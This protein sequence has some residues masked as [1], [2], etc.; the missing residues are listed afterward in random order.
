MAVDHWDTGNPHTRVVLGVRERET[1]PRDL[2]IPAYMAHGMR[3]GAGELSTEWLDP[4]TESE[5]RR[6]LLR[7]TDQERLTSLDRAPL[8]Q[9]I[10]GGVDFTEMPGDALNK[11]PR[12]EML[13]LEAM[14]WSPTRLHP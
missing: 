11:R 7:E 10:V 1:G 9:A 3:M 12:P 2:V 14:G 4:R 8:R 13:R 6:S 5:M